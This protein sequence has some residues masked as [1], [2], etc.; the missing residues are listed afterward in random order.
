[1]LRTDTDRPGARLRIGLCPGW[2]A[3]GFFQ[4]LV[5]YT[6][7]EKLLVGL[8]EG[9]IVLAATILHQ[10]GPGGAKTTAALRNS[11]GSF[12]ILLA[13]LRASSGGET[14]S[15]YSA[16]VQIREPQMDGGR[17]IGLRHQEFVK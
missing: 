2:V 9:V 6:K 1:M 11:S 7:N 16:D 3:S 12:A 15:L 5:G 10:L 17:G 13:I 4:F 8:V 14:A